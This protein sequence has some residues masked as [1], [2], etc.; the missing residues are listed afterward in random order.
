MKETIT[1]ESTDLKEK[2]A[3]L[4]RQL[5]AMIHVSSLV[6]TRSSI[7][8]VLSEILNIAIE[9]LF[10][11]SGSIM[12]LDAAGQNLIVEQSRGIELDIVNTK[13]A[14]GESISGWVAKNCEP[15]LLINGI[16]DPRFTGERT[17]RNIKDA[18]SVPLCVEKKVMGVLNISNSCEGREFTELDMRL[19]AALGHQAGVALQK[20]AYVQHL[21][22]S[23]IE[24]VSALSKIVDARDPY[25]FGHAR[26]VRDYAMGIAEALNLPKE[27]LRRLNIAALLHDVGKIAIRDKVLLKPESLTIDEYKVIQTHPSVGARILE[28]VPFLDDLAPI[29]RHHHERYDGAGY[30]SQLH[31]DEIPLGSRIL[32]IADAFDSMASNR[33]YR[34]ALPLETIFSELKKGR[35]R[36]FDPDLLDIFL[37]VFHVKR[38][39]ATTSKDEVLEREQALY[40]S[41]QIRFS[42][43]DMLFEP[44]PDEFKEALAIITELVENL[45]LGFQQFVGGRAA[46][47]IEETINEYALKCDLPYMLRNGKVHVKVHEVKM[48]DII[49]SFEG[50]YEELVNLIALTTGSRISDYLTSEAL[51]LLGEERAMTYSKMFS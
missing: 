38:D 28:T 22:S 18:I 41:G 42:L 14:L 10:A 26:A 35:G 16:D 27:Q 1:R 32:A 49:K 39:I 24:L 3:A 8:E 4:E 11:N 19:L 17:E 48:A 31:S 13:V 46:V 21:D 2:T 36:Q 6:A 23:Y 47:I 50:Y 5:N 20:S 9:L 37:R 43:Y 34:K 40:H 45:M 25:T 15:V 29:V 44:R 33:P 30:P 51:R 12:I 7:D